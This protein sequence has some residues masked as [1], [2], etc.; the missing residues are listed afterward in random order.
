[1]KSKLNQLFLCVL[2]LC[3]SLFACKKSADNNTDDTMAPNAATISATGAISISSLISTAATAPGDSLYLVGCFSGKVKRDTVAFA[4]LPSAVGTYLQVNYASYI[5]KKAFKLTDNAGTAYV[6][7][8]KFNDK[9]I[10]LKFDAS[11]VFVKV[12]EQREGRDLKGR[13]WHDGG[14]F[15]HRDG[16]HRDTIALSA[17]PAAV[18]S[19]FVTTYPSD[20]LLHAQVTKDSVYVLLSKNNG[21][22]A[23]AISKQGTLLKRVAVD[24]VKG[25]RTEVLQA[26]LPTA[27]TNYLST[28]YPAYVFNKAYVLSKAGTVQAYVVLVTVNSSR[29][30]FKFSASGAFQYFVI[31]N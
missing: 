9:P 26:N 11:G 16:K 15:D 12:L 28:T 18:K 13:G 25:I 14:R 23:T 17:L 5:F 21:L 8:I 29:Y 10:G 24:N 4:A 30:A 6:V 22:F 3:T 27:I 1:M 2:F 7:V 31:V 19:I 20:T